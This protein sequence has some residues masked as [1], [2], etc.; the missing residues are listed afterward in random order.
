MAEQRDADERD[1][2]GHAHRPREKRLAKLGSRESAEGENEGGEEVEGRLL[3]QPEQGAVEDLPPVT[4]HHLS[5]GRRLYSLLLQESLKD[6]RLHDAEANVETDADQDD[7]E[8]ERDSPGTRFEPLGAG[9]GDRQ[10]DYAV[11]EHQAD[12]HTE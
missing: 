7:A 2:P 9:E 3:W 10:C 1:E 5:H 8:Q 6:G 4:P 11:G 12:G